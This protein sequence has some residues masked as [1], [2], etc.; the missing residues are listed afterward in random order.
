MKT[1]NCKACL[2][3]LP[4]SPCP[5][6][7]FIHQTR[8]PTYLQVLL[9][10]FSNLDKLKARDYRKLKLTRRAS[11]AVV[12][13]VTKHFKKTGIS[14]ISRAEKCKIKGFHGE[15]N[16]AQKV[17]LQRSTRLLWATFKEKLS[18]TMPF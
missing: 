5:H 14:T 2:D 3:I 11:K 13:K 7:L 12:E 6:H 10:Y 4:E 15:L 17:Q 1:Q 18:K 9:C 16:K 8:L